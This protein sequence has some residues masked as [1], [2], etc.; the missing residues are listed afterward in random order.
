VTVEIDD[1]KLKSAIRRGITTIGDATDREDP[2]GDTL[3][4]ALAGDESQKD[5]GRNLHI[6][7]IK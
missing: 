1:S 6:R 5:S 7:W 4:G 2:S 3:A